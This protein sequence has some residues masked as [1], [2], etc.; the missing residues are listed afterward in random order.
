MIPTLADIEA[1]EQLEQAAT[2]PPGPFTGNESDIPEE[3]TMRMPKADFKLM[4]VAR[5]ALPALLALA[6]TAINQQRQ[7]DEQC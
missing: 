1:L 4:W 6:R 5:N 3:V 2:P 7:E